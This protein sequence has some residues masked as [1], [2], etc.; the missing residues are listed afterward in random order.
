[1]RPPYGLRARRARVTLAAALGLLV[2]APAC[3]AAQLPAAPPQSDTLAAALAQEASASACVRGQPP[4]ARRRVPVFV[5]GE[6]V[7]TLDRAARP[8]VD[9]AVQAVARFVRVALWG[10][11]AAADAADSAGRLPAADSLL[12]A[13]ALTGGVR[14]TVHKGG[15]IS[16]YLTAPPGGAAADS[17]AALLL[18]RAVQ[19]ARDSND[20]FVPDDL[21]R[22]DSLVFDLEHAFPMP[23][24]T[25]AIV[26][27]VTVRNPAPVFTVLVL[28]ERE[29]AP[30]GPLSIDY[31][32]SMQAR[33]FEGRMVVQFVIDTL[34]RAEPETFRDANPTVEASLAPDLRGPYR[35]FLNAVRDAVVRARFEPAR[36]GRC[37]VR[38]LVRQPVAF[39]LRR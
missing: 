3:A 6:V 21:L 29:A 11:R 24:S 36:L 12:R 13:R 33:G 20:L 15:R 5:Y 8:T 2:L 25:G 18:A 23:D 35:L 17:A 4:S 28:A 22:G 31:P 26:R 10:S 16:W 38:Q 30:R 27:R 32:A 9:L 7:D 34:G 19:T 14:V 37:A 39:S 1:M